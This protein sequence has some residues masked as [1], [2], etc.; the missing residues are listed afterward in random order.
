MFVFCAALLLATTVKAL[1]LEV[2]DNEIDSKV[3]NESSES[4]NEIPT[5]LEE[6]VEVQENPEVEPLPE[7]ESIPQLFKAEDEEEDIKVDNT[8]TEDEKSE[9]SDAS[10]PEATPYEDEPKAFEEEKPKMTED[11]KEMLFGIP[12]DL[13]ELHDNPRF[14]LHL[15]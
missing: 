11:E 1:P 14:P 13:C 4:L 3:S 7:D 6:N 12:I 5:S 2:D 10:E 8:A 15:R 9:E